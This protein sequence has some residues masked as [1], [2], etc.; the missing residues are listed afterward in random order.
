MGKDDKR[1]N[2]RTKLFLRTVTM[3]ITSVMLVAIVQVNAD[4]QSTLTGLEADFAVMFPAAT[5]FTEETGGPPHIQAFR[6]TNDSEELLGFAFLT[7]DIEPLE[8]GYEGPIEMLVGLD[9]NGKL[10]GVEMIKHRE[11][12]GYFSIDLPEFTAQFLNKSILDRFR[13]GEDIDGITTATI[14]VSSATRA[15]RKSARRIASAFLAGTSGNK[16]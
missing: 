1:M 5:R 7:L 2:R 11:P 6:V 13:V 15:I 9:V 16:H 12:Y 10:T 8:R 3:G 14:T 4:R